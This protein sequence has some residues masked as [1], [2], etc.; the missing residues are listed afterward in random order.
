VRELNYLSQLIHKARGTEPD[1]LCFKTDL[2]LP[3][4]LI[5]KVPS[6][7]IKIFSGLLLAQWDSF[8]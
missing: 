3:E 5:L 6:I 7:F 4:A 2:I 8:G 1:E